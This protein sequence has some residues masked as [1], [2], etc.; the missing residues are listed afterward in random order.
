MTQS[1]VIYFIYRLFLW[2]VAK[3]AF[4]VMAYFNEK[5]RLGLEMRKSP[6]GAPW[7][8]A[9]R[10]K[11]PIWIH[12]ASGEFEY[13][14][15]VIKELQSRGRPKILVTYFSPSVAKSI[16]E[17]PGID[18]SCPLPWDEPQVLRE[19][20]AFHQPQVLLIARTDTWPEMLRTAKASGLKTLL[21]SA[22]LPQQ[23]GRARGFG[24]W[25]SMAVFQNLDEV[26]CV[27]EDD[28]R[29][30]RDL[31]C[32]GK[33]TVAGDTRYDQVFQRL[34][35]PK[36]I[37]DELFVTADHT[38]TLVAGSTWPEDES[39]LTTVAS[40]LRGEIAVVLVPHEP[41]PAHLNELE[42]QLRTLGLKSTRYSTCV[43]WDSKSEVLLVD[44]IGILA[45]L[46][47]KGSL[48]F[49]GGS[50]RKTVHSVME[51]LA[52]GAWTFVGPKHL[53][54]R[55]ALFFKK[56]KIEGTDLSAVTSCA[57]AT[58][59]VA[60]LKTALSSADKGELIRAQV[61]AQSGQSARVA[62]W[63]LKN[64]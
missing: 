22:T 56:I 4:H 62:D 25:L 39:I 52:A 49:V 14:K 24:R 33:T 18:F 26:F 54:N 59:F 32:S 5:I 3:L 34:L 11:R 47:Q 57:D 10:A 9:P 41:T 29:V 58:E 51:P 46:Y 13:A 23:S 64:L 45:E 37:R 38:H 53:N 40:D 1:R 44:K 7:L 61:R 6:A 55:E 12:C 50:Y 60:N 36:P 21:F 30:F 16:R 31:G 20:I 8:A 35:T 17:F 28:A 27:T 48:A 15:P 19:F 63:A 43:A 42:T 2:P